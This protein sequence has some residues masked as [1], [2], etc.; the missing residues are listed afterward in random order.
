MNRQFVGWTFLLA[1]VALTA[2]GCGDA[3]GAAS[4]ALASGGAPAGVT[5]DLLAAAPKATWA[6]GQ[7]QPDGGVAQAA[8]LAWP[9]DNDFAG[10]AGVADY[11]LEDGSTRP[12]LQTH[13]MW[14]DQGTVGG[15]FPWVAL[16]P[17]AVFE[18]EVGFLAGAVN[19]D[20]VI[21]QVYE[22]HYDA[23]GAVVRTQIA[24][25]GK[26][27]DGRPAPLRVD[28]SHLAG[29]I[30]SLELRVD[31]GATSMQ[32]WAVWIAPRISGQ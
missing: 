5:V 7:L 31:A 30:V 23:N 15:R 16:P 2:A 10:F 13:P 11:A 3:V 6:S 27:Y 18:A 14:I 12:A 9:K 8:P 22:S 25:F 24:L 20:G 26:Q 17:N 4:V 32:D 19:S 28:L 29:K 21:F 1:I